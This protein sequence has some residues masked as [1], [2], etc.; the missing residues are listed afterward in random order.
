MYPPSDGSSIMNHQ[1]NNKLRLLTEKY[2]RF[3]SHLHFLDTCINEELQPN[4]MRV[5]FG[6]D[7]LPKVVHLHNQIDDILS[8]ATNNVIYTCRAF[9]THKVNDLKSDLDKYLYDLHQ[10]S[11]S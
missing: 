2:C 1:V 8:S 3:S 11:V 10:S 4:G 5:R 6:G 7:A 9:Y